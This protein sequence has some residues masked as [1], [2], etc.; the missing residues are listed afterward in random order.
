MKPQRDEHGNLPAYAWP[1]GHPV[2]YM[3][4]DNGILC[5]TCANTEPAVREADNQADCPDYNQW[6]IV[7]SDV[8]WEDDSLTCDHCNQRI[9]SAY[10][11][12]GGAQ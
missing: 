1:G 4:A 8:N 12:K 5:P 3:C 9:E 2:F 6:R 11:E 7:A 10:A